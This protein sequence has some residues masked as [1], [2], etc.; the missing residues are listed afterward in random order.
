L[1]DFARDPD[2]VIGGPRV[3]EAWGHRPLRAT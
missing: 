1:Y 3:V 2:T